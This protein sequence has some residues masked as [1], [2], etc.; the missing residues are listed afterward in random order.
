MVT[1]DWNTLDPEN[2][3]AY[4]E[5][6]KEFDGLVKKYEREDGTRFRMI[7]DMVAQKGDNWDLRLCFETKQ[8]KK[9][10]DPTA[11]LIYE[12]CRAAEIISEGGVPLFDTANR[13]LEEQ[14]TIK[15]GNPTP[16]KHDSYLYGK[17]LDDESA[18]PVTSKLYRI[19]MRAGAQHLDFYLNDSYRQAL[20]LYEEGKI[21]NY[22]MDV[23]GKM[24]DFEEKTEGI[25]FHHIHGAPQSLLTNLRQT[26]FHELGHTLQRDY[27]DPKVIEPE[28]V[29]PD[30]VKYRNFE[31]NDEYL[32]LD[33]NSKA[34]QDEPEYYVKLDKEGKHIFDRDGQL[35]YF[36]KDKKGEEHKIDEY[37][38]PMSESVKLENPI[39]I[40][41]S[42]TTFEV[43][44][45]GKTII[46]NMPAEGAVE[47]MARA[48]VMAIAPETKDLDEE[49]Y[50]LYVEAQKQIIKAR[51]AVKEKGSTYTILLTHSSILKKEL[52]S[53]I[54]TVPDSRKKD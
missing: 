10:V 21:K 20:F 45:D 34:V 16:G 26:I 14:D 19:V 39:C 15:L 42:L 37:R 53:I 17:G 48:M 4:I 1:I 2:Q 6:E 30:G 44:P 47:C 13:L 40:S 23:T 49:R 52:E 8:R 25:D 11:L 3:R 51:D 24:I 29:G 7:K 5:L 28:Y 43:I 32:T 46:I 41:D 50:S 54:V 27:V 18:I 33:S 9:I 35:M 22:E 38:F 31:R 36:Y 12:T